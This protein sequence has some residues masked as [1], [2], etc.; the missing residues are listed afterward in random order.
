M[1]ALPPQQVTSLSWLGLPCVEVTHAKRV[2]DIV[3]M[4][5]GESSLVSPTR[6][7]TFGGSSSAAEEV[8]VT[9]MS[10]LGNFGCPV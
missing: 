4:T 6:S 9:E 5:K 1:Q 2:Y 7:L 3:C 8:L 10:E